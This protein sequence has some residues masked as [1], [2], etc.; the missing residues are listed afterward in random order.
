MLCQG[1]LSVMQLWLPMP[2]RYV[3]QSRPFSGL[4]VGFWFVHQQPM[5]TRDKCL[6]KEVWFTPCLGLYLCQFWEL[7]PCCAQTADVSMPVRHEGSLII[8]TVSD[9]SHIAEQKAA[10]KQHGWAGGGGWGPVS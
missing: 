6:L 10:H 2:P 3:E 1:W 5:H 7:A 4:L 9:R 8:N